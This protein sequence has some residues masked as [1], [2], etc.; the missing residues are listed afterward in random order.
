MFSKGTLSI[1][2]RAHCPDYLGKC[3]IYDLLIYDLFDYLGK[4][5]IYCEDNK[6]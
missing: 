6:W 5:L 2:N 3:L 4:C 1:L